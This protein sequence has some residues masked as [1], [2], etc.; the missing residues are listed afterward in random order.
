MTF[1]MGIKLYGQY[2]ESV[3]LEYNEDLYQTI[4]YV[5]GFDQ[6]LVNGIFYENHYQRAL[7]HPF[8]GVDA[9]YT[10]EIHFRNKYYKNV[11]MKLD[12]YQHRLLM[13]YHKDNRQVRII[14]PNSFISDFILQG[15]LF[16]NSTIHNQTGFYQVVGEPGGLQCFYYWYKNRNESEH[17]RTTLSYAFTEAKRKYFLRIDNN[18]IRYYNNSSFV[19]AFPKEIKSN[20]KKYLKTRKIKVKH[21]KDESLVELLNYCNSL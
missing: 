20:I 13:D 11:S 19:N 5:Y 15:K 1:L 9:F 12:I 10:G 21:T 17:N 6:E 4:Q 16:V 18:Y 14:I 8:W 3:C 2:Q 7:G